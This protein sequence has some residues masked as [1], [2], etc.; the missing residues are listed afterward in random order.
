[1][2]VVVQVE[3]ALQV[4]TYVAAALAPPRPAVVAWLDAECS[5]NH[6]LLGT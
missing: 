6:V 2:R 1:M 3:E 5:S 4:P